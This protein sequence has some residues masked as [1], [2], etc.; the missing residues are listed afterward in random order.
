MCEMCAGSSPSDVIAKVRW[1]IEQKGMAIVPISA[2]PPF[3]YTVGLSLKALP[4]LHVVGLSPVDAGVLLNEL[5]DRQR[6]AG[7]FENEQITEVNGQQWRLEAM[8]DLKPL[9][10]VRNLFGHLNPTALT[11]RPA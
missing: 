9:M 11:V 8:D 10:F 2:A 1:T 6:R 4:E 5:A 3:A 7:A